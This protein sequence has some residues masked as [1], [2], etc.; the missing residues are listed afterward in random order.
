MINQISSKEAKLKRE[1]VKVYSE[2]DEKAWDEEMWYCWS[3]GRGQPLSHSH[4][5]SR[6]Q[7]KELMLDKDNI[8]LQC[9]DCHDAWENRV[10]KKIVKFRNLRDMLFYVLNHDDKQFWK[11]IEGINKYFENKKTDTFGN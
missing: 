7:D 2:V 5:C 11:L 1:L 3:C 4:A 6:G 9:I 8:F 10:W